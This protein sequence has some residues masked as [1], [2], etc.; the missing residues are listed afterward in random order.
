MKEPVTTEEYNNHIINIF[1]DDHA[2]S[3]LE[4]DNLGKFTCFHSRLISDN[5]SYLPATI[6]SSGY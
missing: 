6:K 1:Y 2:E 5:Y 3:P 4:W